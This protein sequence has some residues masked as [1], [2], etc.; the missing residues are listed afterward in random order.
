MNKRGEL[1]FGGILLIA[2]IILVVYTYNNPEGGHGFME[3]IVNG[4]ESV[5]G[6][7][8]NRNP[9][10]INQPLNTTINDTLKTGEVTT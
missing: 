6:K 9:Q 10:H 8:T 5:F 2:L 1:T 3:K 7:V 4:V